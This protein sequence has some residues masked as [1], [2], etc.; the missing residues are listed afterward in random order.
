MFKCALQIYIAWL[1]VICY[2]ALNKL[3]TQAKKIPSTLKQIDRHQNA[4][5]FPHH[6]NA[7]SNVCQLQYH[8]LHIRFDLEC[9]NTDINS[10]QALHQIHLLSKAATYIIFRVNIGLSVFL[11]LKFERRT[12]LCS[13]KGRST[14]NHFSANTPVE[15][16]GNFQNKSEIGKIFL[17]SDCN[18]IVQKHFTRDFGLFAHG[19]IMLDVYSSVQWVWAMDQG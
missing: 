4:Y 18:W 2:C 8:L 7:T 1:T 11:S 14:P 5:F 3:K 16:G 13:L 12:E 6:K 19:S 15:R 17:C 9:W 10:A